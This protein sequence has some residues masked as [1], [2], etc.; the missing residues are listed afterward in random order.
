MAI[1]TPAHKYLRTKMAF[2]EL[3]DKPT[4]SLYANETDAAFLLPPKLGEIIN[5]NLN[6]N[7]RLR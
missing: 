3:V 7:N 1:R 4:H 5:T 2:H 6:I